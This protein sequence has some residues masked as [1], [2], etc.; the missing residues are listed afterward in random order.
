MSTIRTPQSPSTLLRRTQL[1]PGES[2]VSLLERLTL[3]NYYASSRTLQQICH[4]RLKSPANQDDLRLPK[5]AETF[6][7]LADLTCISPEKLF[8]ASNH[9]FAPFLT[10]PQQRPAEI[11]W[12]GSTSKAILIPSLTLKRI[13][14][15]SAA[16]YCPRCLKSAAYHRL[17][18]VPIASTVCLEHGYLLTSQCHQC[19]KPISVH[20]IVRQRCRNC[21]A[22]LSAADVVSVE[23]DELGILSQQAIQSWLVCG[24]VVEPSD[25]PSQ[26][27]AVLYCFLEYLSRRLLHCQKDWPSL[28]APLDGLN[29]LII[30]SVYWSQS[31]TPDGMFRLLKAAF[32]GVTN[33]PNGLFQFLDAYC[34]DPPLNDEQR[35]RSFQRD[36]FQSAWKNPN[37]EFRQQGYVSYLLARNLPIP[38]SLAERH[39]DVAWFVEQTGL[40]SEERTAQTLGI[41]LEKLQ[42]LSYGSMTACRWPSSRESVPLFERD[43]VLALNRKWALGWSVP[44]ASSWLGLDENDAIKLVKLG[45]LLL[46]DNP[47]EDENHWVLSRQSVEGYFEKVV[48]RLEMYRG[49]RRNL[50]C[51]WETIHETSELGMDPV[52]LLQGVVD[53]FLPAYKRDPE[54]LSLGHTCFLKRSLWHL[55]DLC[56]ARHGWVSG[57]VFA[58]EKGFFP[59]I[60]AAWMDAGLIK[61]Q[62]AFGHHMYFVR[63]DLEEL[64]AKF[65]PTL[66]QSHYL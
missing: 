23:D 16:Q 8:A 59:R 54:I 45:E 38:V 35:L 31:L 15:P 27:P 42:S 25:L 50:V 55:P 5:W 24:W 6:C 47:D 65:I 37:C 43:K 4:S 10:L 28:P 20:E 33:W 11:P 22:D 34:G 19:H 13:R 39:K 61:P 53:G 14:S 17:S 29:T 51:L 66:G 58:Y 32:T 18:W 12:I 2:L 64:A 52:T 56:Y 57:H 60:V 9:H 44:E 40:W 62:K 48:A 63:Q 26:H 7:Q 46:V 30:P 41:P 49:N 3:L 36:W 21:Q 1:F